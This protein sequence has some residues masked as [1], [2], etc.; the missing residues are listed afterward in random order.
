MSAKAFHRRAQILAELS[1]ANSRSSARSIAISLGVSSRTVERDVAH[2]RKEGFEISATPGRNGGLIYLGLDEKG[3]GATGDTSNRNVSKEQSRFAYIQN[4]ISITNKLVSNG[5]H[6]LAIRN[7]KQIVDDGFSD[8]TLN[9]IATS[10]A[11]IARILAQVSPRSGVFESARLI[12]EAVSDALKTGNTELAAQVAMTECQP[13]AAGVKNSTNINESLALVLR[14][15]NLTP[16][17]R[18][19]LLGLY[20]QAVL[21]EKNDIHAAKKAELDAKKYAR[22][23]DDSLFK[24]TASQASLNIAFKTGDFDEAISITSSVISRTFISGFWSNSMLSDGIST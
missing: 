4:A 9:E 19:R 3:L 15:T 2:L 13:V 8:M 17:T 23:T 14:E 22:D 24:L 16:S 11:D 21:V 7:L 12:A 18:A 6:H 10:K 1:R 5:K 20:S